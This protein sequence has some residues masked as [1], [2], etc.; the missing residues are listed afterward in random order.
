MF[1]HDRLDAYRLSRQFNGRI[2]KLASK[3]PKGRSDLVHQ[4]QRA[5]ASISLNL[6]EGSGEYAPREKARFYRIAR[7]SGTECAAVLD[8]LVDTELV[9]E[10]E[11]AP[12]RQ[13][14]EQIVAMLVKLIVAF[15]RSRKEK[16]KGRGHV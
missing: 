15:E 10:E 9:R 8:L 1:D 14:L 5:G 4:L 11:I 2:H 3:I 12:A 7:R 16:G 13:L 6:A